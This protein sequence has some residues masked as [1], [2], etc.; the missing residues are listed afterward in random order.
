MPRL[1]TLRD[2]RTLLKERFGFADFRAG[3]REAVKAALAGRDAVVVLPTG[4]GKSICYQLPALVASHGKRKTTIVVS[5]LIALMQDQVARLEQ[6]GIVAAA[7]HSHQD[8]Q[9]SATVREHLASGA[10]DLLYV[11]PERAA[12]TAFRDTLQSVRVGLLAIDEAH[13]VS[14]WGH[15]FRPDYLRLGELRDVVDAPVMALTATA[16]PRVIEEM[17]VRL[18]LREP[19]LVRG[20]FARPNLRFEVERTPDSSSKL[21]R[22]QDE[23]EARGFR[24]RRGEGR[25]LVYCSTRKAVEDVARAL[26]TA[27][28]PVGYYH[29]GRSASARERAQRSFEAART[30]VL[31]ATN[32]FGM[33]I[34]LPDVRFIVHVQVPGSL[35]AYYQEAGRAGR[36]GEPSTCL[37]LFHPNDVEI[38]RRLAERSDGGPTSG[39][40]RRS[41][42]LI[43]LERYVVEQ[44]CRQVVLCEHFTGVS[45][46]ARCRRCDVCDPAPESSR[47]ASP[48]APERVCVDV[49]ALRDVIVRAAAR[50]RRPVR[51][52][53]FIRALVGGQ[54]KTLSRGALLTLPEYGHLDGI[55]EAIIEDEIGWLVEDGRL[56]RSGVELS[57][58]ERRTSTRPRRANQAA[59]RRP[60]PSEV[61]RPTPSSARCTH[62]I[63]IRPEL[64]RFRKRMAS[65]WSCKASD[66]LPHRSILALD[67]H[68]PRDW[69][70]LRRIPGLKPEA[71]ERYGDELL[72]LIERYDR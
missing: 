45:E 35:E 14:H 12:M 66:V 69:D 6:R 23:L 47:H 25:A 7:L 32:A 3:Q 41:D 37:L 49:E 15:D 19:V 38:Q 46:H 71:L 20:E 44:R 10:L 1:G 16:T 48:P 24:E 39:A 72:A 50:L 11:S 4:Q 43:A 34:D 28:Y 9:T 63:S 27:G 68:R 56:N 17:M 52:R 70:G 29:A 51:Q 61:P 40:E 60:K 62:P 58:A 13:C 57:S 18:D 53:D 65:Q 31:V 36:D 8:A 22:L 64:D 67:R 55:D 26:R 30:R 33:G 42:A 2:A 54:A 5:P 21:A 59:A